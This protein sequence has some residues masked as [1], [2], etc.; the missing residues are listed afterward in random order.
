MGHDL[1]NIESNHNNIREQVLILILSET[2]SM[3]I[4]YHKTL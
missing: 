2:R 3:H 4:I 1:L